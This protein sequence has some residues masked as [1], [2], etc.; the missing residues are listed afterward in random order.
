M[1]NTRLENCRFFHQTQPPADFFE[2]PGPAVLIFLCRNAFLKKSNN[3]LEICGVFFLV[4]W[5]LHRTQLS[6]DC[7]DNLPEPEVL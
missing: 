7:F 5:F 2:Y 1:S 4:G 3:R 6:L